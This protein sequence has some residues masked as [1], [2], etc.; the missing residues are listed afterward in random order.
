VGD[1]GKDQTAR[2]TYTAELT[3]EAKILWGKGQVLKGV[4]NKAKATTPKDGDEEN[5]A[6]VQ[7]NDITDFDTTVSKKVTK[8]E[9]DHMEWKVTLQVP[10]EGGNYYVEDRPYFTD[11]KSGK[12]IL[13]KINDISAKIEG[14]DETIPCSAEFLNDEKWPMYSIVFGADALAQTDLWQK[15][16]LSSLPSR[17]DNYKVEITYTTPYEKA[18]G[19]EWENAPAPGNTIKNDVIFGEDSRSV[20]AK[21]PYAPKCVKNLDRSK[22]A[23]SD[24]WAHDRK[25]PG[26][27]KEIKEGKTVQTYRYYIELDSEK[28]GL[29][30][31]VVTDSYSPNLTLFQ[32]E[33]CDREMILV[34]YDWD[35]NDTVGPYGGGGNVLIQNKDVSVDEKNHT[36]TVDLTDYIS[37][38]NASNGGS[39]AYTY[40]LYYAMELNEEVANQF[41][42]AEGVEISNEAVIAYDGGPGVKASAPKVTYKNYPIKKEMLEEPE[43]KND[44]KGTFKITVT[45]LENLL[46]DG[47]L[48]IEDKFTNLDLSLNSIKV[49]S[50]AEELAK[51]NYLIKVIGDNHVQIIIKNVSKGSVYSITYDAE[52]VGEISKEVDYS[53][54]ASIPGNSGYM[55]LVETRVD[56]YQLSGSYVGTN[57]YTL[58][59]SKFDNEDANKKLSGAEFHVYE[60]KSDGEVIL[61]TDKD[62]P[63]VTNENGTFARPFSPSGQSASG[64]VF[65]AFTQYYLQEVKAPEGYRLEKDKKFYFY[66]RDDSND[67]DLNEKEKDL[68]GKRLLRTSTGIPVFEIGN[69][70]NEN[71]QEETVSVTGKKTWNDGGNRSK[72]RPEKISIQLLKNGE[73]MEGQRQEV[74]V[75]DKDEGSWSFDKLPKY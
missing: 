26:T 64:R 32:D 63:L 12:D 8:R 5:E 72:K 1:L 29:D 25:I 11:K 57:V 41:T 46:Q 21:I 55:D 43:S 62:K 48:V 36:F 40:R 22:D 37:K 15:R 67:A 10:K 39:A 60:E 16:A 69:D 71:N 50:G 52:V 3:D 24:F 6:D 13:L 9:E 34:W 19:T 65:E 59:I 31:A 7:R 14:T 56:S 70:R 51:E 74:S 68:K 75:T 73:P 20:S 17:A 61:L 45:A 44:Y 28:I 49:F 33:F 54:E 47:N 66:F 18:D 23:E 2:L 4:S 42:T 27:R 35:I 38:I 30:Q 53:N 58:Q